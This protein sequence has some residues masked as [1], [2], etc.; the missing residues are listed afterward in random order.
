MEAPR[1]KCF[2]QCLKRKIKLLTYLQLLPVPDYCDHLVSDCFIIQT[3]EMLFRH[4]LLPI[5]TF[6]HMPLLQGQLNSF[7]Y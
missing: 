5:T 1:S 4:I 3:A 2:R 6:S 7:K